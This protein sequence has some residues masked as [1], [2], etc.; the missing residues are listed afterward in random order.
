V[1]WTLGARPGAEAL[2]LYFLIDMGW[3]HTLLPDVNVSLPAADFPITFELDYS[4]VY[5]R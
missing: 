5:L 2:E 1:S 4:R 3:G